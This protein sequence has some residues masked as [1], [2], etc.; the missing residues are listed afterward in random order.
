MSSPPSSSA[1]ASVDPQVALA[2]AA[3][4]GGAIA[5]GVS[6]VF[7]RFAEVGPFAS[8]FWRVA[9]SLPLLAVW[10]RLE[11]RDG[12]PAAPWNRATVI[13]G[14]VFAG[15][16]FFW[17]LGILN[18]T[19]ANATFLATMAPLWVMLGSGALIRE[20][21]T[22]SMVIGLGLCLLGAGALV[23]SSLGFAPERLAGDAYGFLT[24]IFFGGYF[25][26]MRFARRGEGA[27]TPGL[28]LYR[29]TIITAIVLF[30]VALALD[31]GFLPNSWKGVAALVAIAFF[32]QTAGQG[33]LT[34]ALGHL[35]AGFSALVIFLEA[36]AAAAAGWLLLGEALS[37]LQ[38]LGGLVILAGIFVARP[39]SRMRARTSASQTGSLGTPQASGD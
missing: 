8:A 18:T 3:L 6:P 37:G 36:I 22:R 25:L 20:P 30:F 34:F 33:L 23:G 28:L 29:S 21:V 15:D 35:S 39:R 5:M 17:H 19:I 7:V 38:A 14:A 24:S 10:A 13:A 12:K 31:D 4:V 26:A 11:L 9:L 27:S 2:L 32:S 16:L 1:P